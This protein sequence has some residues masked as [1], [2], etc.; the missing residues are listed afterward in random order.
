MGTNPSYLRVKDLVITL[1]KSFFEEDGKKMVR[2]VMRQIPCRDLEFLLKR[3]FAWIETP[4]KTQEFYLSGIDSTFLQRKNENVVRLQKTI[5]QLYWAIF[6]LIHP[7]RWVQQNP[8]LRH[9]RALKRGRQLQK[10]M[11]NTST[12]K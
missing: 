12:K 11:H 10:W 1:D 6:P 8:T 3:K 2:V 4:M 5:G 9:R 7:V